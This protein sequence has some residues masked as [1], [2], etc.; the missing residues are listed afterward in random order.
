MSKKSFG[1]NT[2]EEHMLWISF[3]DSNMRK[4][5]LKFVSIHVITPQVIHKK[6][7]RKLI[8]LSCHRLYI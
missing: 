5:Q 1:D 3:L 7:W 8:K 2:M 4:H 6:T